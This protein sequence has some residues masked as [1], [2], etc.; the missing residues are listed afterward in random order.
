MRDAC[1][2]SASRVSVCQYTTRLR[3]TAGDGH[4]VHNLA[5]VQSTDTD[6]QACAMCLH[7]CSVACKL[8]VVSLFTWVQT[9]R[10]LFAQLNTDRSPTRQRYRRTDWELSPVSTT[11]VAARVNGPSWRVTGFHYPSTRA[12]NSGSQLGPRLVEI[13]ALSYS[14]DRP[15]GC[16]RDRLCRRPPAQRQRQGLQT[17]GCIRPPTL[18]IYAQYHYP[19]AKKMLSNT[20]VPQM[21]TVEVWYVPLQNGKVQQCITI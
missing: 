9:V 7:A 19:V 4:D 1:D 20:K 14:G 18:E 10:W 5:G 15:R 2:W 21:H 11:R 3:L 16:I 17:A 6:V 12:V 13:A 8:L